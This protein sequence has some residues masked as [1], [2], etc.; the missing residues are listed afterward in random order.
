MFLVCMVLFASLLLYRL[1][2]EGTEWCSC[3][4]A[5]SAAAVLVAAVGA[6]DST[7]F[8]VLLGISAVRLAAGFVAERMTENEAES[9]GIV[10]CGIGGGLCLV[11]SGTKVITAAVSPD[12][13]M[14]ASGTVTDVCKKERFD[15]AKCK[16]IS[17]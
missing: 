14:P 9:R 13:E 4:I 10:L 2:F 1:S 3:F 16:K 7:A 15:G 5:G 12:S 8:A 6:A 11:L 17:E